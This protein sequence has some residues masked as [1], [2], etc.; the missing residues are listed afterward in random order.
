[1][2]IKGR[3]T[4]GRHIFDSSILSVADAVTEPENLVNNNVQLVNNNVNL[5]S[6]FFTP[7]NHIIQFTSVQSVNIGELN[8][9]SITVRGATSKVHDDLQSVFWRGNTGTFVLLFKENVWEQWED[10]GKRFM[11]IVNAVEIT[12][13]NEIEFTL[14][15][16]YQTLLLSE[17]VIWNN[18]DHMRRNPGDSFFRNLSNLERRGR[19]IIL[20]HGTP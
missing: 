12:N 16:K 13:N 20:Q 9:I 2:F 10:S 6:D 11:G 8:E 5:T 4:I 19:E 18:I 14:L 7:V 1:M 3:L 17:G 15:H